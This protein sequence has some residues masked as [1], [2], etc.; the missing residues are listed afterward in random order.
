MAGDGRKTKIFK[1]MNRFIPSRNTTKC[2]SHH[3]KK[4]P[5][6][7]QLL[8]VLARFYRENYI[9]RDLDYIHLAA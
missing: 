9:E 8:G 1:H 3:Q 2:R 7:N 6:Y 4:V 5:Q